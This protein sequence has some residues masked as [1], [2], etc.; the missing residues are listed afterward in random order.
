MA[1]D[2]KSERFVADRDCWCFGEMGKKNGGRNDAALT[3]DNVPAYFYFDK[4][5]TVDVETNETEITFM[6][7]LKKGQTLIWKRD[8]VFFR[9]CFEMM[10]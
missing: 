7:P 5:S 3:V 4:D 2:S 6:I 10:Y 1:A 9:G 8:C